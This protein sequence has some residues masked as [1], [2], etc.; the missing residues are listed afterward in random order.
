MT[1]AFEASQEELQDIF[2]K[3]HQLQKQLERNN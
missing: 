2:Q 3:T 1:M